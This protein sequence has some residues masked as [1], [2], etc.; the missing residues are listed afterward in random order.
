MNLPMIQLPNQSPAA[1]RLRQ[2]IYRTVRKSV[3]FAIGLLHLRR[4]RFGVLELRFRNRV[5]RDLWWGCVDVY[6]YR[7]SDQELVEKEVGL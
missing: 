2:Y 3:S 5:H 7:Q 4:L 1:P 6:I